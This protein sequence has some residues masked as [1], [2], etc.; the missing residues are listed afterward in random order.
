MAL[1]TLKVNSF[2]Y[3][4]SWARESMLVSVQSGVQESSDQFSSPLHINWDISVSPS[5]LDPPKLP[6]ITLHFFSQCLLQHSSE[7]VSAAPAPI[8]SIGG[9][10][11]IQCVRLGTINQYYSRRGLV[12][13]QPVRSSCR[14][15]QILLSGKHATALKTESSANKQ[16]K[17]RTLFWKDLSCAFKCKHHCAVL[18]RTMPLHGETASDATRWFWW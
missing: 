8:Q 10:R 12:A 5:G 15:L 9:W 14:L 4:G 18:A 13:N 2:E 3:K 16:K 6:D 7:L 1:S 11:L 17:N